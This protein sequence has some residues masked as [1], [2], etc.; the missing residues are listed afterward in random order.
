MCSKNNLI[1]NWKQHFFIEEGML[2]LKA[3][4]LA[5]TPVLETSAHIE[6]F[7]NIFVREFETGDCYRAGHLLA[8]TE[9]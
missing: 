1:S 8:D 4:G 7:H 9:N 6:K 2:E 3:S 5:S